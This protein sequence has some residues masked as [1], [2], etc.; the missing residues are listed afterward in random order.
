MTFEL[1]S[2]EPVVALP[3]ARP[4]CTVSE[5]GLY[6]Y[7]L[8]EFWSESGAFDAHCLCNPSSAVF[9]PRKKPVYDHTTRKLIGFARHYERSG[10]LV[11][12]PYAFRS[13]DPKALLSAAD[14]CGPE[15]R[16]FVS[17][18]MQAAHA[19]GGRMIVGWGGALPK[20]LRDDARDLVSM[21][22]RDVGCELW[23]YGLTADGQP[24]HPLTL[25]YRTPLQ[26]FV[27]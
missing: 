2:P 21:V 20:T 12:N 5:C 4:V 22:S 19:S 27:P 9:E 3:R 15:N 25:S 24:T 18:W 8:G 16:S 17:R 10:W 1:T 13:R 14:P 26:R 7:E 11:V 6:R 23:C